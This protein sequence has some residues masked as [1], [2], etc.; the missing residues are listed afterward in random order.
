[1]KIGITGK[2]FMAIFATCMLVLIT[3]H[4]GVRVSFERG[5]IDYIK[6]S[7]EQRINM[8]G[9]ALEEQYS[10]HGNWVFLR[11]NDQVVYQIMRSFEQN[12]DSSHNLPP[13]GW[14]TQFWVVDSQFN[15]LVGHSGPVPREGPRHPI[16]YNN[17]IVGWVITTPIERLTRN[18]DI[19]FDQQQRRTSWMIVA[20]STLLAAAVTWLMSRGLLAPVKRLVAGTHR[21]AAGDFSTRVAVSSQDELG[22]L[23]QDFNQLATSLEKNEQMRRA[24]MADVSHE[25][26]TP[27][28]ILR[29]ELEA[30]QDGVRQPT[31]AS[32][33]SLQAEVSTLTKLVDDL[34]QLSLS[35]LGA[36]AYRKSPVDC[37]HLLQIAVASFRER[38]RAKELEIVTLLPE[39][40]LLFGDPDRLNQLFNN[41]LEN[42]LRYTDAGGKLEIG[43]EQLPGCLRIYW[44]DSAPGVTDEQLARIFERFYRTEGSR[45]R[46]SGGS[47]LGLSICQN[48]VEA[49]NGTI[50]AQHSPL[51]GVRITVEFATPLMNKAS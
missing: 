19:N 32:L 31:P 44:Q 37:V 7:N 18:T 42:S 26:R 48:I 43:A 41:L 49:H 39:Q 11:N 25:L 9:E 13:K 30:L 17:E 29:G 24:V 47:G 27:L 33:N 3:M 16:R 15:R 5:F 6:N 35:D 45:N 23:A 38:F 51:G 10:R 21:L 22:R 28:A 12:S 36:L 2:L 34:H 50:N 46:A 1:M 8:L 40:A 20:L 14:R 4:W